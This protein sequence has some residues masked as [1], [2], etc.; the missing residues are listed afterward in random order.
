M[1][2]KRERDEPREVLSRPRGRG[3]ILYLKPGGKDGWK[4]SL[5]ALW[6]PM[7]VHGKCSDNAGVRDRGISVGG[8]Y[9]T[10]TSKTELEQFRSERE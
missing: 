1:V 2:E 5:D 8:S 6:G 10:K 3:Q 4:G 7:E 9:K